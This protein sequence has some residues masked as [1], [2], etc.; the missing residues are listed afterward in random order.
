MKKLDTNQYIDF[1]K[2]TIET[3]GYKGA[4]TANKMALEM[5]QISTKQYSKAARLIAKAF[6]N[7]I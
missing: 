4:D 7:N 2:T 1:I 5:K 3:E 6:L